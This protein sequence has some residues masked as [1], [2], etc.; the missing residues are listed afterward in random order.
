[1]KKKLI[2]LALMLVFAMSVFGGCSTTS[3]VMPDGVTLL[4]DGTLGDLLVVVD[5]QNVYLEDQEW[6]CTQTTQAAEN[7]KL[8]IDDEVCDNN[9]FTVYYAPEDPVGT[10]VTYNEWYADINEDEWLNAVVDLLIEYTEIYPT[11][12]K[13]TYSSFGNADF[14][15]LCNYADRIILTGVMAECCV[16]ATAFDAIDAGLEIVYLTD[17]V[18][19]CS[20]EYEQETEDIMAFYS[21][22]HTELMTTAEYIASRA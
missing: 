14:A 2:T 11:Y 20:D 9:V 3:F 21:P 18:A 8:L 22:L 15:E 13:S 4:E 6:A 5:M 19:G 1:M 7:I 17:A 12:S 16:L 10:W